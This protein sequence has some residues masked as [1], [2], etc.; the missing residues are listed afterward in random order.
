MTDDPLLQPFQLRHLT[1]RNRIVSTAHEPAYGESGLP[2]PRYVAYHR[3]KARGGV[4]MTMTAG[5]MGVSRDSPASFGNLDASSDAIIE[6]LRALVDAVHEEGAVAMVQITHL[7]RRTSN[8]SGDWLPTISP[9]SIREPAHRAFPKEAE[10]WDLKR[11]ARDYGDAAWRVREAG[12][13]GLEI[14]AYGHLLD[15]FW[16]RRSNQRDDAYGESL[17]NRLRFTYEVLDAVRRRVGD[18][19]VVGMRLVADEDCAGG[20]GFDEGLEIIRRLERHGSIDFI[21]LIKGRMDTDEGLSRIIPTSGTPSGPY[22]P[23]VRAIKRET[24]LPVIH[25]ARIADLATARYAVSEGILDLVGMTRAHIA[26]PWLVDKLRRGQEARIRPCVGASFCVDRIHAGGESLCMHNPASG[27]ER[28]LPHRLPTAALSG[29]RAVVVGAGPAG[30]EAARVLAN[31]GHRVTVIEAQ[32]QVGGQVRLAARVERR[33]SMQSVVDWLY[34]ECELAGVEFLFDLVAEVDDVMALEPD[35][36]IVATGGLPQTDICLGS[37][38]AV[39]T[40]DVLE[41]RVPVAERVLVYDD[42]G[43]HPAL[44]CVEFL[45]GRCR[46]LD[47]VSPELS[48]APDVGATN[49]PAYMRAMIRHGVEITLG[50]RLAGI[51]SD[52]SALAV[53][54]CN[55]YSDDRETRRVDRVVVEHGCVPMD[56]LYHELKPLSIN[57]G[58]VDYDA[59]LAGRAQTLASHRDG[60]FQVF[61]IGDAVASRNV[62]AAILD[63]LRIGL[64]CG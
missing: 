9:S 30:L 24:D 62:H 35:L 22:L 61:R 47:Y 40:W 55:D 39:S 17:D 45:A 2:G 10:S 51:E 38:H 48:I 7:G 25:A 8:Y 12:M 49:R 58:E 16:S 27:R 20:L 52:G 50:W 26:D 11:I 33:R 6:P 28:Q 56:A 13:D 34:Q 54:L 43:Q 18:D 60:S 42:N 15:A 4:G 53:H 46:T 36:V 29:R 1:I 14:E 37:H 57:G 63:G 32:G 59:L 31:Q 21:N 64:G 23:F 41:G 19:F 5:S 44:S 3:E